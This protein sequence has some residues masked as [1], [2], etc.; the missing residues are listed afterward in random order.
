MN[1]YGQGEVGEEMGTGINC[2][3]GLAAMRKRLCT[4]N[5]YLLEHGCQPEDIGMGGG[6]GYSYDG[7]TSMPARIAIIAA[8]SREIA[9]LVG[10]ATA[11]AGLKRVGVHLYRVEGGVVVAAGMGAERA[12]VAVE[13][14]L[15]AGDVRRVVSVGLA[16]ACDSKLRVGDVVRAGVVVDGVSGERFESS[17]QGQV[18]VTAAKVVGAAEKQRLFDLYGASAVD[19]EAAAVG[20]LARVHGLEFG[21]IKS[22]SDEA[23]FEMQELGRFATKDGQFREGAFAAYA[24]VRP[25]M[26]GKVMELAKN[27]KVAVE[28]LTREVLVEMERYRARG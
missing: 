24:A 3:I 12:V 11:D 6:G 23:D 25:R 1:S 9:G 5:I 20:R 14:A 19:M 22:I 21:A 27:S 7:A 15:A 8:L 18:L 13:A 4:A 28:A 16:G 10:G 17:G 2:A 26:W